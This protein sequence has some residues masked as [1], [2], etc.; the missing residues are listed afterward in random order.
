MA[1]LTNTVIER[2]SV[3]MAATLLP[4]APLPAIQTLGL[5]FVGGAYSALRMGDLPTPVTVPIVSLDFVGQGYVLGALPDAYLRLGAVDDSPYLLVDIVGRDRSLSIDVINQAYEERLYQGA[6]G[7][8]ASPARISNRIT[9]IRAEAWSTAE[10]APRV[11]VY[12]RVT[13][14]AWRTAEAHARTIM[15][16]NTERFTTTD[17]LSKRPVKVNAASLHFGETSSHTTSFIRS[18]AEALHVSESAVRKMTKLL[19]EALNLRD[20]YLRNANGVV[21][22]IQ[23]N[24]TP[25]SLTDFANFVNTRSPVGFGPFKE[26][27]AGDYKYGDALIWLHLVSQ[28]TSDST[29]SISQADLQVDVPDVYDSDTVDIPVGGK[30]VNFN[31][32]FNVIPEITGQIIGGSVLAYPEITTISEDGFFIKLV[33]MS[34]PSTSV[35]GV[36]AY[37]ASGY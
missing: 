9:T 34:D 5:D 25:L 24:N 7:Y 33:S 14:E 31:R 27:L 16:S 35:E 19:T 10:E 11:A 12:K 30:A 8:Y 21:S 18:V 17:T 13:A 4:L 20:M 28:R 22:D 1:A 32:T 37:Q 29:I 23:V 15:P 36:F 3:E 6:P 2:I 26:L